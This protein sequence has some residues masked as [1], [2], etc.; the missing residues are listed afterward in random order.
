MRFI[1]V[2]VVIAALVF[3]GQVQA[4]ELKFGHINI[5]QMVAE[6]PEKVAADKELQNEATKLQEQLQVMQEDIQSL[7]L[8]V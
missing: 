8:L 5:Q 3:V 2:L 6:L 4:Q 7:I 1:K